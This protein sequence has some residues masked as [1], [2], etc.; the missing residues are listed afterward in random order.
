MQFK[1]NIKSITIGSFDGI[2][3]GHSAL[4]DQVEAVVVIERNGGYL[5]PGYKRSWFIQKPCFFYYFEHIYALSAKEFVVKLSKDFPKLQTIV[6]GYDFGFGYKKEGNTRVLKELFRGEVIVVEEVKEQGVSVHSRIIRDYIKRA[7]MQKVKEL[8]SRPYL[9]MGKVVS[10]QG[11]GA[12]ALVP[13]LNL[14]IYDYQ[15]PKNGVY[16]TYTKIGDDWLPSISFIG[17]RVTTDGVFAVESHILEGD[18]GE[19]KG[20]VE[21]MFVKFIRENKKFDSLTALRTQ[22]FLDIAKAEEILKV[23]EKPTFS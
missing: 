8:L 20:R 19:V 15:L 23:G 14:N 3:L 21:L 18:I 12:K 6:V 7:E 2:H 1:N 5:T 11:L 17:I 10:G 16:A 9:I 4:I 22:I 13:T